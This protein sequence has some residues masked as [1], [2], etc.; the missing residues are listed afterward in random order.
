MVSPSDIPG[1]AQG[2][3]FSDDPAFYSSGENRFYDLAGYDAIGNGMTFDVGVPNF[4]T[5]NGDRSILL[6]NTTRGRFYQANPWHGSLI[7]ALK[8]AMPADGFAYPICYS[9]RLRDSGGALRL[10][11][12]A[13]DN[14]L[15]Y[16]ASNSHFIEVTAARDVP[17]IAAFAADQSSRRY[18]SLVAGGSLV[19]GAEITTDTYSGVQFATGR[20]GQDAASTMASLGSM[21]GDPASTTAFGGCYIWEM[22]T[23][24][25]NVLIANPGAVA[26]L[27][28]AMAA[29]YTE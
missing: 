18:Y 19:V 11:R 23:F 8:P 5:V 29:R 21:N 20:A 4:A 7:V 25:E 28:I 24:S 26:S 2:F 22:H 9:G 3:R 14:R 16:M 27:L 1:Y 10:R 6:D 12:T 13:T 17:I 15:R